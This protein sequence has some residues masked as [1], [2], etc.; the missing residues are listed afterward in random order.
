MYSVYFRNFF[1]L[2][3]LSIELS[4]Q[5]PVFSWREIKTDCNT[6][7]EHMT[8]TDSLTGWFMTR[9]DVYNSTD[10][11]E[12]WQ[13]LHIKNDS[14][15]IW[16]FC[17]TNNKTGYVIGDSGLILATKD[18]GRTWVRQKSNADKHY[19]M[20]ISFIDE[21]T[22]WIAGQMDDGKKRGGILLHTDNGGVT[23]DTLSDRSDGLQYF[24]VKFFDKNNGYVL[25][26]YGMDNF[27]PSEV[28]RTDDGGRSLILIC[29]STKSFISHLTS[30][31]KD[32]L[33]GQGYNFAS[34]FDG[35]VT[36]RTN[37]RFELRDSLDYGFPIYHD[38]LIWGRIGWN[39]VSYTKGPGR[40]TFHL[41]Y[42]NDYGSNFSIV[43]TPEGFIPISLCYTGGS[44]YLGGK[45]GS[46]LT[47][48]PVKTGIKSD[49]AKPMFFNLMQNYPNPFNPVTNISY[50]IAQKG[51]VTLKVYNIIG[52]EIATLVSEEK[53]AGNYTVRFNSAGIPSGI[54]FYTLT[55]GS[56]SETKKLI[57]LK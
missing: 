35:G 6:Y 54:Y 13:N 50:S 51:N 28:F 33:W 43:A 31:G 32:T 34:S 16:D 46:V 18:G 24:D 10:R 30:L 21:N 23:W 40:F 25:A 37:S 11:G 19:L 39:I 57:L 8:F 4:A 49:E 7:I 29:K 53:A 38:A 20:G 47:S 1:F 14:L 15:K 56:Y 2:L 52:K 27:S 3:F 48:K 55:S 45:D 17:F 36:W 12:T 44:F 41:Y 9:N 22:G 5:T 26:N 42:T